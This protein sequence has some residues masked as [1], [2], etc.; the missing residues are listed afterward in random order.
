[1]IAPECLQQRGTISFGTH[2]HAARPEQHCDFSHLLAALPL[3][4]SGARPSKAITFSK[5]ACACRICLSSAG[6]DLW[7]LAD[8]RLIQL[9]RPLLLVEALLLLAGCW[10]GLVAA[11][12]AW[13]ESGQGAKWVARVIHAIVAGWLIAPVACTCTCTTAETHLLLLLCRLWWQK[14]VECINCAADLQVQHIDRTHQPAAH[15]CN[16]QVLLL[17]RTA[18]HELDS[19]SSGCNERATGRTT[20]EGSGPLTAAL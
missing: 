6:L 19:T 13:W 15:S 1:M 10:L 18:Q 17:D 8:G 20:T 7:L 14:A 2:L 5:L 9:V 3:M 16:L 11:A 12:D 4:I